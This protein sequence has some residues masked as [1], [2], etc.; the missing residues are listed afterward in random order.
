VFTALNTQNRRSW[1]ENW[2]R[3]KFYTDGWELEVAENN[4]ADI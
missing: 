1:Y 4:I 3:S 2:V